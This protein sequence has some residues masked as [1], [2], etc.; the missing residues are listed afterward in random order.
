MNDI[1]SRLDRFALMQG[2]EVSEAWLTDLHRR[3]RNVVQLSAPAP[4]I[5]ESAEEALGFV[6]SQAITDDAGS[7]GIS[8]P[9]AT[10][11]RLFSEL[12]SS[13]RRASIGPMFIR[14]KA[15]VLADGLL[16]PMDFVVGNGVAVQ[17]A[18]TWSFQIQ[19][20]GE[21]ARDVKS[22]GFTLERLLRH[23]GSTV[24]ERAVEI[25]PGTSVD[26]V[27]AP[28]L[29]EPQGKAFEEAK[30]VFDDLGVT[31]VPQAEI[32]R[33]ADQARQELQRAGIAVDLIGSE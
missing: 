15:S 8:R 28:P 7:G 13:Y 10:R 32:A 22:W 26:V 2:A 6:F 23:G 3:H 5:A 20:L 31:A 4:V 27:Y 30:L 33:V 19:A 16:A 18:H 24:G 12:K 25:R 1:G 9:Y 14:E 17:L 11:L 21:V 29:T